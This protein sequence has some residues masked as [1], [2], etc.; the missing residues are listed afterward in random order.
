[1]RSVR[2]AAQTAV[3]ARS[4]ASLF[5][6]ALSLAAAMIHAVVA[7][8]HVEESVVEAI[9]FVV[10]AL[11]QAGW[12]AAVYTSPSRLLLGGGAVL[13]AGVIGVWLVSRTAGVPGQAPERL[14]LADL[15]ATAAEIGI[16]A[17]CAL[18]LARARPGAE[19]NP[20]LRQ[21]ALVVL[22]FA[23][24]ALVGGSHHHA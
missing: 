2:A 15:G 6:A 8:P 21:A 5:L 16:C 4:E 1:V 7:V 18:A 12:G 17:G 11:A 24:V 23:G 20:W 14:G 22:I 19:L 3:S 13:N 9:L 10:L